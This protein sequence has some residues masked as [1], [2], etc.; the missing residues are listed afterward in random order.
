M[1]KIDTTSMLPDGFVLKNGP[2]SYKIL[3]PLAAGGFGNTY[4][5]QQFDAFGREL[6][7]VALKE[8]YMRGVTERLDDTA[9]IRVSNSDNIKQFEEQKGK[10]L[11]EAQRLSVMNSPYIVK[12][13]DLFEA[14]GTV[15]YA[16]E[17]IKGKSIEEML[18]ESGELL[19]DD[20]RH[21]LPQLLDALSEVHHQGFQHLDIKPAN[22]MLRDDSGDAVLIDFGASKQ[23]TNEEGQATATGLA[24]TAGYAPRE[25]ME[26]NIDKFGPWTDLYALGATIYR[27]LTA[28]KPP[29]PSDIEEDREEALVFHDGITPAM[30]RLVFWLMAPRRSD[31]PQTVEDVQKF[32]TQNG[33]DR[34][35][36]FDHDVFNAPVI[37]PT[38]VSEPAPVS[39]PAS[40][41]E[42]KDETEPAPEPAKEAEEEIVDALETPDKPAEPA[43]EEDNETSLAEPVEFEEEEEEK[44]KGRV[45]KL[46][47]FFLLVALISGATVMFFLNRNDGKATAAT[48]QT[49]AE[50]TALRKVEKEKF[51][52]NVIGEYL[53]TGTVDSIGQPHDPKGHADIIGETAVGQTYDGPFNHGV[54][55]GDSAKY[56]FKNGDFYEGSFKNNS[57]D[58][59]R[60]TSP[61]D[62][63]Y[64]EG[65]F[66]NGQPTDN[67]GWHSIKQ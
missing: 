42:K 66:K 28:K 21:F 55:E 67:N 11:K 9:S 58:E 48:E 53:Y 64:Y 19:E 24:F 41:P 39:A 31:R 17:L 33:L 62:K 16:M 8:F 1:K 34:P 26:Q 23:I 13:H 38:P 60:L 52:N 18:K 3:A 54:L 6:R 7:L 44:P 14:N 22:I 29:M 27:T 65:K 37:E 15:Y 32:V 46:I 49:S 30:K 40:A 47:L 45:L 61:S 2:L 35:V 51:S 57:F 10:L 4:V 25:Q 59:G 56:V 43:Y 50:E 20:V 63:E 5:A 36:V 12:V